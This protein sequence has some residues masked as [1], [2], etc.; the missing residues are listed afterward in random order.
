MIA[1]ITQGITVGFSAGVMP[2]PMQ[3]YLLNTA[4]KYGWRRALLVIVTP[5]IVDIPVIVTVLLALDALAGIVPALVDGVRVVGGGFVLYLAWGAWADVRAGASLADEIK[6]GPDPGGEPP[7]RTFANGL[8]M[9]ALSPGPYLFWTTVNGPL[10]LS[11]L[12]V[13]LLWGVAFVV[14]FYGTFLGA[15]AVLALTADRLRASGPG[16]TRGLLVVVAVLLS[17]FGVYLIYEGLN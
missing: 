3:S 13:S 7:A 8:L 1:F 5:L 16:V 11:A 6:A 4:L 14:A 9:N 15:M 10:L 17:G 2:G 12:E